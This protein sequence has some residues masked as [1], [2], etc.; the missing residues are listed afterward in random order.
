MKRMQL[1]TAALCLVMLLTVGAGVVVAQ[2]AQPAIKNVL[3]FDVKLGITDTVAG[4]LS[5]NV[6]Q[7]SFAFSARGLPADTQYYIIWKEQLVNVGSGITDKNGNLRIAGAVD[8]DVF[9]RLGAARENP[10]F[11]LDTQG[12]PVGCVLADLSGTYYTVAIDSWANGV[13]KDATTGV[14]LANKDVYILNS[15]D[16]TVLGHTV[17][18]SNG[19]WRWNK[20]FSPATNA[21]RAYFPGDATYCSKDVALS[22]LI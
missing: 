6:K 2:G 4:T 22:Y 17:T 15:D 7:Q 12:A 1:I 11:M 5:I 3:K 8:K 9:F 20:E 13:L 16:K 21:P 19:E 10:T 18:D 14:G